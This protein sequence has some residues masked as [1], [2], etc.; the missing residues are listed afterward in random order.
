[1][2]GEVERN[3]PQVDYHLEVLDV[4]ARRGP[5]CA[6]SARGPQ[7]DVVGMFAAKHQPRRI[8]GVLADLAQ[9][10]YALAHEELDLGVLGDDAYA[11]LAGV[12]DPFH[13]PGEI[14]PADEDP[15]VGRDRSDPR[16]KPLAILEARGRVDAG[17]LVALHGG[18]GLLP[19]H[20]LD[21]QRNG[22]ALAE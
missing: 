8:E 3:S 13:A 5:A 21:L 22:A 16:E 15:L 2:A 14:A 11:V 9:V 18:V 19:G 12:L 6:V 17:L 20:G 4:R 7:V 1:A 10:G